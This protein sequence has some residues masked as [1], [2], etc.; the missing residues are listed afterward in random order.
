MNNIMVTDAEKT[1]EAQP[2]LVREA[3]PRQ[4]PALVVI[5]K[6]PAPGFHRQLFAASMLE[7]TELERARRKWATLIS[8]GLQSAVIGFLILMPLLFPEV[9]PTKQLVSF[10]LAPPPPPPP[11]PPA[12]PAVPQ[13]RVVTQ[14]I[15]GQLTTPSRIP[16]KI[17]MIKED[18]VPTGGG[19][20]GGVVGGVPGGQLGGVLG[21]LVSTP[22]R[23]TTLPVA[24]PPVVPQRVAIS[25]GI[26]EGLLLTKVNPQYPILALRAHVQ[27]TVKLRA[28]ISKQGTI[29]NL[30]MIDGHPL[31]VP[32]AMEAVKSWR[33]RPYLLSGEPVEVETSII[34]NF[35][36]GE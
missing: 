31:L 33:Y 28:I 13:T 19:V 36:F 29:E 12:A 18:A 10:L 9:L 11:P 3:L 22:V 2:E 25:Q 32:A 21:G 34:V 30:V 14:F 8:V 5:N 6:K 26:S 27:G 23:A 15:E 7:L 4:K 24:P 17:Q 16:A 1:I 20:E 35:H